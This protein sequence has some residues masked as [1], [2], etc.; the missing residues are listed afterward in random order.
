ML[1]GSS[2]QGTFKTCQCD[3]GNPSIVECRGPEILLS[4]SFSVS[5]SVHTLCVLL[6]V[7][8]QLNTLFLDSEILCVF[9]VYR[10]VSGVQWIHPVGDVM[11]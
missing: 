8:S 3:T 1:T 6:T 11:R 2:L 7:S 9:I 4:V 5:F 10:L